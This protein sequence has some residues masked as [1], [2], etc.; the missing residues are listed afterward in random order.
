M[1]Y[2]LNLK[3]EWIPYSK[4]IR[5]IISLFYFIFWRN[6]SII[7]SC[8]VNGRLVL[9]CISSNCMMIRQVFMP[10]RFMF[11]AKS[12]PLVTL[13]CHQKWWN[14]VMERNFWV[15]KYAWI[16]Q[17]KLEITSFMIQGMNIDGG[18][19][20]DNS[21][22]NNKISSQYFWWM[23]CKPH[24]LRSYKYLKSPRTFPCWNSHFTCTGFI[25]QY[26]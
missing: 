23:V 5:I 1:K 21:I 17:T 13:I 12:L 16:L 20:A 3:G 22:G 19:Y 14:H 6:Y 26:P 18:G 9:Q 25:R 15:A 8:M 7:L 24:Y 2:T 4:D 10:I 11:I